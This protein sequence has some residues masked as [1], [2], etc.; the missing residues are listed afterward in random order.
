MAPTVQAITKDELNAIVNTPYYDPA[1][2]SCDVITT[3]PTSGSVGNKVFYIGDSLTYHL[4]Q[5]GS[6]KTKSGQLLEK[7]F[8]AEYSVDKDYGYTPSQSIPRV[9]GPS[10]EAQGGIG[11]AGSIAHIKEDPKRYD[12]DHAD[13]VVIALGTNRETNETNDNTDSTLGAEIDKIITELRAGRIDSPPQ[14]YWVNGY[15]STPTSVKSVSYQKVNETIAK[16]ALKNDFHVIDY[17]AAAAG[18]PDIAPEPWAEGENKPDGIHVNSVDHRLK[19]ADWIISQLPKPGTAPAAI[20]AT[21]AIPSLTYDP[22]GLTYPKFPD[23]KAIADGITARIK[24]VAPRSPFLTIP[25]IGEAI[26]QWIIDQSKERNI[27]PLFIVGSAAIENGFGTVGE[28]PAANNYF[29]ILNPKRP[30]KYKPFPSPQAG[31]QSFMDTIKSNTQSGTGRYAPAKDIYEYFSIH[32]TGSI[33][34]PGQP[35]DPQDVDTKKG[36]TADLWDVYDAKLG[37]GVWISWD[38]LKNKG[39][40]SGQSEY[41]PLVYYRSNIATINAVTGLSLPSENPPGSGGAPT[42]PLPTTCG[43]PTG[44]GA[45]SEGYIFP[46]APQSKAIGGIKVGQTETLHHDHTPAFDLFTPIDSATVYAIYGGTPTNINTS[47]GDIPGC[48]SIQFKADDGF[49]Y[50]YGHLQLVTVA[51]GTHIDAGTP[52]AK[53][54]NKAK[55]DSRCYGGGPHLHIDRG[56]TIDGVPQTGGRDECRDPTFIPFLAKIYEA[57]PATSPL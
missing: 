23:E 3:S 2:T 45:N 26:G 19:K 18:D 12:K 31:I 16:S 32:Q 17:A 28:G 33:V 7:T 51:E 43:A 30:P 46:L 27:N 22:L 57:L 13:I 42:A 9:S 50:W 8:F 36:V 25:G 4:V 1:S 6:D 5:G 40:P 55:F 54:A 15:W 34:Y 29:G 38:P 20:T 14:I 24:K 11:V 41:N 39:N 52:M 49:Y 35:L 56:C 21:A 44:G 10:V 47:F 48:S 53:I 37:T